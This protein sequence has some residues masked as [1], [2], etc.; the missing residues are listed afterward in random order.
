MMRREGP[1]R[2]HADVE[3]VRLAATRA[4]DIEWV[5]EVRR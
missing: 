3:E 4:L 1:A 5:S 2:A